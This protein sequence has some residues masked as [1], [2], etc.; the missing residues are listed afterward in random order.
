L[1]RLLF[2]RYDLVDA[3]ALDR[4][5]ALL[6]EGAWPEAEDF[7]GRHSLDAAI[8]SSFAWIDETASAL[9]ET[10]AG[11]GRV[12]ELNALAL[13]YYLVKLLRVVAYFT[14][15]GP[16][17]GGDQIEL[18]ATAR[19]DEDYVDMLVQLC[20]RAGAVC[21]VRWVERGRAPAQTF[22]PNR[23]WRQIAG[24]LAGLLEPRGSGGVVFCGNP[25]LLGP[26]CRE[27]RKQ[28]SPAW[29]LFDR[30]SPGAWRRWRPLGCGQW[31]CDSSLG[32]DVRP[33]PY[34]ARVG[35][36][37]C[38]GVDL[39]LAVERFLLFLRTTQGPRQT[40]MLE[41]LD[42]HFRQFRPQA[43]VLGEDA[44]PLARAAA[45]VARRYGVPSCVLQHGA[46]CCRFGFAPLTA[47][48]ILVWGASSARQLIDWGVPEERIE[49]V[50]S[51]WHEEFL[52]RLPARLAQAARP[53]TTPF[54]LPGVVSQ[55]VT[56][57]SNAHV[58]QVANL[59]PCWQVANLPH[60]AGNGRR[61]LNRA[62]R[63]LLL[64][65]VPP[66]DD[67]PDAVQLHLTGRSYREMVEMALSVVQR[68]PAAE[69]LV[70]LHPRAPDDP[71]IRAAL[72][73]FPGLR[74]RVV[75]GRLDRWLAGTDC[76]LSC[77]SSA[78]VDA[79]LAGLPVIQLLPAGSGPI[80]PH[81]AWGMHGTARTAKELDD[82]L[83]QVL[84]ADTPPGGPLPAV[85]H[86]LDGATA[87]RVARRIVGGLRLGEPCSN[88]EKTVLGS[89]IRGVPWKR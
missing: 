65:T 41:R 82:Q 27:V 73:R 80:L 56:A 74:V 63:I 83:A 57:A 50:G 44:T 19:R 85:F 48:R 10:W 86:R 72:A 17:A 81:E 33:A 39:C 69:L 49:I 76:V 25:T 62:P 78:G 16:L 58:G 71:L 51:P 9:A 88:A 4:Q 22:P 77:V 52:A 43:L 2:T 46:P 59:P 64:A 32:R 61:T 18:A 1:R 37:E 36:I 54:A 87:A 26:L 67:R 42:D 14:E 24:R 75:R 23:R 29:W 34:F 89:A 21:R 7:P 8:G 40:R 84:A 55:G 70:K 68:I 47:D 3:E 53:A 38:R 11:P 28:G 12:A 30:F 60:G 5:P 6:L 79:A 15:V 13:R 20:H 35:R 45:A 31:V 66:R